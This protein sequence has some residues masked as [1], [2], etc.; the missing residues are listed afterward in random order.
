MKC[1][2]KVDARV[3]RSFRAGQRYPHTQGEYGEACN[4]DCGEAY[5]LAIKTHFRLVTE[6]ELYEPNPH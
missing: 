1:P 4:W 6:E 3:C 5:C 2:A